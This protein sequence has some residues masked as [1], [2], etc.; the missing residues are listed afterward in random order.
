MRTAKRVQAASLLLHFRRSY[1][2]LKIF[3]EDE[4]HDVNTIG[5]SKGKVLGQVASATRAQ[6]PVATALAIPAPR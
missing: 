1:V 6:K 3:Q 4:V 5:H 2:Q